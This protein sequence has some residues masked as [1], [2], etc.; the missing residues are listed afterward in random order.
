MEFPC[1]S[2]RRQKTLI[3]CVVGCCLLPS[4]VFFLSVPLTPKNSL[5]KRDAIKLT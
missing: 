5:I 2:L 3:N 1:R 4:S